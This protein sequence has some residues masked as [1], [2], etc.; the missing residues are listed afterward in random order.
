M[1][2]NH[3]KMEDTSME[4]TCCEESIRR[5]NIRKKLLY[6]ARWIFWVLALVLIGVFTL[7]YFLDPAIIRILWLVISGALLI[8]VLPVITFWRKWMRHC[9]DEFEIDQ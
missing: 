2:T 3:S 7:G 5:I 6:A 9:N 1:K 4:N 8:I